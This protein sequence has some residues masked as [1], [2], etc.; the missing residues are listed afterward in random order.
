MV[1]MQNKSTFK[2]A[3][4]ARRKGLPHSV[5]TTAAILRRELRGNFPHTTASIF[6]FTRQRQKE[7]S[8]TR[9][10]DGLR[11]MVTLD[12]PGN[13]QI[14]NCYLVK[15]TNEIKTRLVEEVFAL[16]RHFKVLL[17]QKAHGLLSVR[18]AALTFRDYALRY[19]QGAFGSPQISRI[20]Y[21]LARA[22]CGEIL[23]P[24]VQTDRIIC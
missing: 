8:P 7:V 1:T 11:Q 5:P 2:A 18:A 13:V 21:N 23:K 24:N 16:I 19:L 14:F 20:I 22:E 3:M 4:L 10:T 15:L 6:R 12:H 9:I 17:S